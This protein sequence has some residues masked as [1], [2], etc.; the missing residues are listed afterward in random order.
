MQM[1]YYSEENISLDFNVSI[2]GAVDRTGSERVIDNRVLACL[3]PPTVW[4]GPC[5]P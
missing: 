2:H 5:N 1:A 4:Y 3:V